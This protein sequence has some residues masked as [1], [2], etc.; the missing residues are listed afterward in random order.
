MIYLTG[1]THGDFKRIGS[2]CDKMNT[3]KN[4]I[5]IVLG[6]AGLNFYLDFRDKYNKDYVNN[7]PITFLCIHGN[8]EERPFNIETYN[9]KQWHCGKVYYEKDFPNILF[10]KDGEIYNLDGNKCIALGGAYSVD[11]Y[12][13]LSHGWPY[14]PSEIPTDKIINYV[15]K[16]LD[17]V[18]WSVDFVLSHTTPLKYE[19]R[20]WFINGIDQSKVDKTTEIWLD[21][22]EDK[23]D[24]KKWYCGHYHGCKTIDKLRI[25]F[26]DY[27]TLGD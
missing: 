6:D 7:L 17:S 12:Y 11:K 23:L 4:D 13:R 18:D 8:H 20:E 14:F 9:V 19:P 22:I 3:C 27:I 5:M 16:K 21:S 1:D 24:Y 2:F 10:A 25:M 26:E 15:N